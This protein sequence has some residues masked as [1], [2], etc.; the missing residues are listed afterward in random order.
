MT[1]RAPH[2]RSAPHYRERLAGQLA[3]L[4]VERDGVLMVHASLRTVGPVSGGVRTLLGAVR[5]AL[6]PGGTLVV[7]TFTPENSDTSPQY[8]ER[9]RGLS[10]AARDAVRAGMPAFDPATSPAPSMGRLAE[11]VRGAEGAERSD[12]PQ[13]SF[14]ALGPLAGKVTACHRRDCHLGEDSPLARL[15]E[16][17]AQVL[18]LGTGFDTC[19]AF[20]LG[21]YRVSSP[22]RRSYRC[23]V[24]DEGGHRWWEYDDVALGDDDFAELGAAFTRARGGRQVRSGP[25]GSSVSRLFRIA[26]AV[27]F[28]TRWLSSHRGGLAPASP[29]AVL[30]AR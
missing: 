24:A 3:E 22:P 10:D 14:A 15:E 12:H 4:G 8:R 1:E 5:D 21:E 28:A 26:D 2:E 29:V 6:G 16:L 9:V 7:P 25:V 18:L 23:V 11:A 20:H 30:S 19:S 13:T 17:G 27:G